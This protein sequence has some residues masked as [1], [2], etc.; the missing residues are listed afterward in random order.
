MAILQALI[1]ALLRSAGR[2]LK[3]HSAAA[4]E[5]ATMDLGMA[6]GSVTWMAVGPGIIFPRLGAFLL[7]FVPLPDWSKRAESAS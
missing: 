6:L 4:G 5:P 3:T 2:V 1:A 7:A